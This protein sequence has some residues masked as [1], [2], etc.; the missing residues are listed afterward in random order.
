MCQALN[1]PNAAPKSH[2]DIDDWWV[3]DGRCIKKESLPWSNN[4]QG[5]PIHFS[6]ENSNKA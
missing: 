4:R 3:R 5:S 6:R 1:N 2:D